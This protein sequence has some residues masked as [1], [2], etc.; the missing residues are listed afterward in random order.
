MKNAS[1][2]A[3]ALK[4]RFRKLVKD[5]KDEPRQSM[6]PLR[7]LL[8]GILS[9]DVADEDVAEALK[10]LD[11]E[12]VDLNELRVATE[13]EV[14]DLLGVKFPRVEEK[15]TLIRQ[16]LGDVFERESVLSFE[17]MKSLKKSEVRAHLRSFP[18]LPP[19][20][21]AFVMM[22]GYDS[23]AFPVDNTILQ[24]LKDEGLVESQTSAEEAQ[25]F[26][27]SN[28]KGDDLHLL[29]RALREELDYGGARGKARKK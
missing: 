21:E 28:L 26:V 6:D 20:V 27:E 1:K 5:V 8:V 10:K 4:S 18:D 9:F 2:H 23:P 25:K 14:Q 12:F 15:A 3:D 11:A 13:L 24:W 7:A 17:R 22:Y 16:T 29:F 19:F